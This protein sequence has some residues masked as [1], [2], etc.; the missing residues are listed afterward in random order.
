MMSFSPHF[1]IF[2]RFAPEQLEVLLYHELKVEKLKKELN[3]F[4]EDQ[5]KESKRGV[6][7]FNDKKRNKL[8]TALDNALLDYSKIT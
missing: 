8:L 7:S 5:A 3:D 6:I 4:D 1:Q 2:R